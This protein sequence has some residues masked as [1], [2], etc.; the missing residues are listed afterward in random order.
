[1]MEIAM[2]MTMFF[3]EHDDHSGGEDPKGDEKR[4]DQLSYPSEISQRAKS[5]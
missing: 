2:E 4:P 3:D 5:E 1:M